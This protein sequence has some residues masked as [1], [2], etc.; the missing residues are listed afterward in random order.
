MADFRPLEIVSKDYEHRSPCVLRDYFETLKGEVASKEV[1]LTT[2]E[3]VVEPERRPEFTSYITVQKFKKLE[4]DARY[5]FNES[6]QTNDPFLGNFKNFLRASASDVTPKG[7]EDVP[8][9]FKRWYKTPFTFV[10]VDLDAAMAVV[11][12]PGEKLPTLLYE[13]SFRGVDFSGK[14]VL[15]MIKS[16]TLDEKLKEMEK[17]ALRFSAMITH[18]PKDVVDGSLESI[19]VKHGFAHY[20]LTRI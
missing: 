1:A 14:T 19:E 12:V 6:I 20:A 18:H 9:I 13:E 17:N 10:P 7:F 4:D 3:Y 5:F 15:R 2:M 11:K 16:D 8:D